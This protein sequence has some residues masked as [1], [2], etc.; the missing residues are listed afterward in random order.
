MKKLTILFLIF[1]LFSCNEKRET[2]DN[3][4][5]LGTDYRLFRDTPVWK[6]A[7]AVSD[8]DLDQI[9]KLV[10][11]DKYDLNFK[12]LKYGKTLLMLATLNEQFKS[13]KKL[14]ELGADPNIHDNYD[15]SSAMISAAA[16]N[17]DR[18]DNT[19]FLRLIVKFNGNVNDVEEGKR[20]ND[21][22]SRMTP[23]MVASGCIN[24]IVSP[25]KKVEFLVKEGAD[26]NYT[27]EFSQTALGQA[28][29]CNNYDVVIYLLNNGADPKI[30]IFFRD[31]K[32]IYIQDFLEEKNFPVNSREYNFKIEIKKILR[33]KG[34]Q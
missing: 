34:L 6:L 7:E 24:K 28:L 29:L 31:N 18:D 12:E 26:V 13:F 33:K 21:N 22:L 8:Q 25:L 16:I 11:K 30:P 15:G 20:R 9:E 4:N 10:K 14:L 17:G 5:L 27:S 23:L 2:N 19:K 32:D 1:M 3:N